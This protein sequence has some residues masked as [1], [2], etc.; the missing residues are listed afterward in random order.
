[1]QTINADGGKEY[2]I[3]PTVDGPSGHVSFVAHN[4]AHELTAVFTA[5]GPR[6]AAGPSTVTLAMAAYGRS[7]RRG[8]IAMSRW[9]A[10]G[11]RIERSSV[12]DAPP[13]PEWYVN[14]PLGLEQGF[15][16]ERAPDGHGHV[17]IELAIDAAWDVRAD[18]DDSR[19]RLHNRNAGVTLGY[20]GL[21]AVDARHRP[22]PA[23]LT[24][25]GQRIAISV[26]AEGATYPISIDP[27]VHQ[28]TLTPFD[29][30]ENDA[31]GAAVA[32]S[33]DTIVVG[34]PNQQERRGAAYVFIRRNDTWSLQAKLTPNDPS[35]DDRFGA[36]V[37]ISGDTVLVG[38]PI[39]DVDGLSNRGSAYAFVRSGT[40]WSQQ[41]KLVAED[42]DAFDFLGAAVAIDTNT[43]AIGA[44]GE[45][46][47]VTGSPRLNDSGAV[48]VFTRSGSSWTLQQKI[49][50]AV[51]SASARFGGDISLSGDALLAGADGETIGGAPAQGSASVFV[52]S[53]TTWS[54]QQKL[55]P[56]APAPNGLFGQAVALSGSRILIGAPSFASG[57]QRL[58]PGS[59][60]VFERSGSTWSIRLQITDTIGRP[61]GRRVA[62]DGSVGAFAN[63]GATLAEPSLKILRWTGAPL[64]AIE[65]A[66]VQQ[67]NV[68]IFIRGT[69]L[70][71]GRDASA[72]GSVDVLV[73]LADGVLLPPVL[74]QP[75]VAGST[76][77]LSWGAV[78]GAN[79]YQ[80]R[81]G[82]SPGASNAFNGDVGNVTSLKAVNVPNGSYFVRVFAVNGSGE[83]AASNEVRVDVG[84][85]GPCSPPAA[86]SNLS[87]TVNGSLVSL[88]WNATAGATS[89]VVEAGSASGL[90]NL[91]VIDT[92]SGVPGLMAN[93]PPGTYFVRVRAKNGC[94]LS[95]P[96]A[97]ITVQ[98]N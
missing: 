53:G 14:G 2:A 60:Y 87:R 66:P 10:D 45:N 59:V 68:P 94:G 86:P 4:A 26:D 12:G 19:L 18:A 85:A 56:S 76:V 83:S 1:L 23:R 90:A 16:I 61:L 72:P 64:P 17:T 93:A 82:T 36:S 62:L 84:V 63:Q 7:D 35:P 29:G 40:V 89:Y 88:N 22:L 37:A 28:E 44:P 38:A 9:R 39:D 96:S 42:G 48:Y 50:D 25:T 73:D 81:A 70:L 54:L 92:G 32:M 30:A 98:V 78:A 21:H 43:A 33:G 13:V 41:A 46:E 24:G 57:G 71:V 95:A 8:A 15:S 58:A 74:S 51:P 49:E 79:R 69:T 75:V 31:F 65:T 27:F 91:A 55:V 3:Q 67:L 52:R 5:A 77:D 6:I 97:Q 34:S 80:L 11:S 47:D 20:S